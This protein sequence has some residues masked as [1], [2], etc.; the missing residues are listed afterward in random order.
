MRR[1]SSFVPAPDYA[2]EAETLTDFLDELAAVRRSPDEE[3]EDPFIEELRS[4]A[5][6]AAEG[7]EAAYVFLLRDTLLPYLWFRDRGYPH[8]YPWLLG[9]RM[10]T[11]LTGEADVDDTCI[12][13]VIDAAL[14]AGVRDYDELRRYC[15]PRIR[16]NL[17]AYPA[18]TDTVR[19]LLGRIS[20]ERIIVVESGVYGTFPMLLAALDERAEVRMF[21]AIPQ[22]TEVYGDKIRTKAYEKNRWFEMLVSQDVLFPVR[23]L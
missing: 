18:L 8:L 9:R 6:W 7:K 4:F 14:E 3:G 5:S 15:T 12:R 17:K 10:M 23:G 13:S 20:Q 2:E 22:M 16:E 19:S 11:A 21:T 1:E